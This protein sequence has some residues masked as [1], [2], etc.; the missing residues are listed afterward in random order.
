MKKRKKMPFT[1]AGFMAGIAFLLLIFFLVITTIQTD[2]GLS[3]ILPAY[4]DTEPKPIAEKNLLRISVNAQDEL[5]V[6][7]EELRLANLEKCVRKFLLEESE[8]RKAVVSI[9]CNQGTS[10]EA[11][12]QVFDITKKI[13]NQIWNKEAMAIYGQPY[14]ALSKEVKKEVRKQYPFV[15]SEPELF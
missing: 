2:A 5:L 6:E 1:E 10:Y 7:Q 3:T 9:E 8:Q 14:S 4:T 12:L 15:L 11:Y 13:Y